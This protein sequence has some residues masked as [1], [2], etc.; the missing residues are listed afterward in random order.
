MSTVKNKVQLC[1]NLGGDPE[2]RVFDNGTKVARINLATHD[3]HRSSSGENVEQT[4]WHQLICW[5]KMA[6]MAE[7]NLKKGMEIAVEGKLQS[8]NY[9]D[10]EGIKRYVTEV[11]VNQLLITESK[12]V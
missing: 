5:G 3:S 7:Q 12:S 4:N 6:D 9:T 2:I 8:R 1:G 11:N 10:K